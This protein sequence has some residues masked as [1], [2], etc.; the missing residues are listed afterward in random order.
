[1]EKQQIVEKIKKLRNNS[2]KR[3]FA[4]TF[5]LIV[6]LKDFDVRSPEGRIN[7]D[8]FLPHGKG[9][10]AKIVIFSNIYKQEEVGT[11]VIGEK[12]I[13]E[14]GKN[15]REAKKLANK[16]DFFFAEPQLMPLIGRHLGIVLGPRGKMPKVIAGDVK[17]L[18]ESYKKAVR[19]RVK[20]N[21]V[22]QIPVGNE[23]MKDEEVAENIAYALEVIQKILP[24]G[25]QN[26]KNVLLKLTMSKPIR[27]M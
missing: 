6:N 12:E 7:E 1:M 15:K 14:L 25:R 26:I 18:V 19:V 10:Q 8:L 23:Q 5:D 9:K 3:N 11:K 20:N 16:T 4:Q 21:P 24:K 22:I 13:I 27:L 17:K 2:K